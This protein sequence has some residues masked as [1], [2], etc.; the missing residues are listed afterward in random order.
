MKRTIYIALALL[1]TT[2]L[3]ATAIAQNT[4]EAQDNSCA[5]SKEG[6]IQTYYDKFQDKTLVRIIPI[7]IYDNPRGFSWLSLSAAYL[8]PGTK[9]VRP[10]VVFFYFNFTA[11]VSDETSPFE[12]VQ[13]V[14]LLIDSKPQSLGSVSLQKFDNTSFRQWSYSLAVPFPILELIALGKSVEMRAGS[15]ELTF[16]EDLKTAFR[17][18]AELTPKETN[19]VAPKENIS[20]QQ[21][22]PPIRKRSSQRRRQ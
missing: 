16:D 4:Q 2:W 18:L 6:C 10:E 15:V 5:A 12:N 21:V 13:S 9:I 22:K 11:I 14:Y 7:R 19:I 8:S 20:T 17:R 3:D 1:L